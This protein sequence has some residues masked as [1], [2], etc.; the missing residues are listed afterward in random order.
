MTID[1]YLADLWLQ[2]LLSSLSIVHFQLSIAEAPW[3]FALYSSTSEGTICQS[4]SV[5]APDRWCILHGRLLRSQKY[6]YRSV[7]GV[8]C[9]Y[10][11]LLVL[12]FPRIRAFPV[13]SYGGPS[14]SLLQKYVRLP[15]LH[16]PTSWKN[17]V[18]CLHHGIFP[19]PNVESY[20]P[21]SP[22][23]VRRKQK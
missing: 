3:R 19:S 6:V 11:G 2:E 1:N 8:L 22:K 14:E 5:H 13:R 23:P 18:P 10:Q 12:C 7:R 9:Q 4:S 15:S 21:H 20:I 17:P 16:L